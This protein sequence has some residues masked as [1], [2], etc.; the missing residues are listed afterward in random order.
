MKIQLTKADKIRLIEAIKNGVVDSEYLTDLNSPRVLSDEV[1]N[2]ELERLY[3]S[4][5]PATCERLRLCGCCMMENAKKGEPEQK[6]S[7]N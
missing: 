5:Y 1:I 6:N 7:E 4:T 3:K 2:C